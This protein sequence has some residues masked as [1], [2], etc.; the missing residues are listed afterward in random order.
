MAPRS[1][2][3]AARSR[4]GRHLPRELCR[5]LQA[6]QQPQ[7]PRLQGL[8]Q[9]RTEQTKMASDPRY[10]LARLA[11]AHGILQR[12]HANALESTNSAEAAH[13]KLESAVERKRR[14]IEELE[15]A[16]TT[17][18]AQARAFEASAKEQRAKAEGRV[19]NET[20]EAER[21]ARLS[22]EDQRRE[23]ADALARAGA[24]CAAAVASAG[25]AAEAARAEA[26]K[27]QRRADHER[28]E[29]ME[30]LR[31]LE[32]RAEA[33]E[34]REAQYCRDAAA[35]KKRREKAEAALSK[36]NGQSGEAEAKAQKAARLADHVS[37]SSADEAK[38]AAEERDAAAALEQRKK[39]G[40]AE[41]LRLAVAA[42]EL[43]NKEASL[44]L[45]ASEARAADLERRNAELAEEVARLTEEMEALRALPRG[46]RFQQFVKLKENNIQLKERPETHGI[47]ASPPPVPSRRRKPGKLDQRRNRRPKRRPRST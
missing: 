41:R 5:N 40:L 47:A 18:S 23:A 20:L 46:P 4:P 16:L 15:D 29:L 8:P 33:S 7:Q 24:E 9:I 12:D 30:K 39:M 1:A 34:R 3:L 37:A 38:K 42:A 19:A 25:A 31:E 11:E 21:Q 35:Q 6:A 44:R 26:M 14:R 36:L 10:K 32:A 45:S 17:L 13:R 28:S 43:S 2:K 27:T 22:A